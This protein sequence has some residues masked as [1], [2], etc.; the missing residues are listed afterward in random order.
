MPQGDFIRFA[1]DSGP[2]AGS[3]RTLEP[4]GFALADNPA[5]TVEIAH[6]LDDLGY[7]LIGIQDHPYQQT[8]FDALARKYPI[9]AELRNVFDLA[10]AVAGVALA[11]PLEEASR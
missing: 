4:A 8:H 7:D 2:R 1:S 6:I 11:R 9:Y 3:A 5:R 10:L